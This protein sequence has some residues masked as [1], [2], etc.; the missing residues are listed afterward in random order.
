MLNI[1]CLFSLKV[2]LNLKCHPNNVVLAMKLPYIE[3]AAPEGLDRT[4]G[5]NYKDTKKVCLIDL[6]QFTKKSTLVIKA[7]SCAQLMT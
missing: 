6:S 3:D 5:V 1:L 2:P 4:V 7:G